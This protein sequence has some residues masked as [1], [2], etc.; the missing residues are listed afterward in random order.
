LETLERV[1][2]V[3]NCKVEPSRMAEWVEILAFVL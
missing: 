2:A 1:F 3:E